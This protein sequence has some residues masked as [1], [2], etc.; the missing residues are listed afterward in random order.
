M[1][2]LFQHYGEVRIFKS[3]IATTT[4]DSDGLQENYRIKVGGARYY[5]VTSSGSIT[6]CCL[7]VLPENSLKFVEISF[8]M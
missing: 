7:G 1:D 2:T 8:R 4:E 6:V 5:I 3:K